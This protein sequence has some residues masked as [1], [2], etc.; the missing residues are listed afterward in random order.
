MPSGTILI[1]D[2]DP[3]DRQMIGDALGKCARPY[4]LR[5]AENGAEV[6]EYLGHTSGDDDAPPLPRPDLILLDLNMPKMSGLEALRALKADARFKAIPVVI[7]TTSRSAEER[8]ASYRAGA[9]QFLTKPA[10]LKEI[11]EML[12]GVAHALLPGAR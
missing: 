1:A 4:Q 7:W 8:D 12:C 6:L 9:D 2:D 11:E 5:F 3:D 10:R